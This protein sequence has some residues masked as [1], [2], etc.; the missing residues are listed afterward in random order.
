[1]K[2]Q[3]LLV[4][5]MA[6]AMLTVFNGFSQTFELKPLYQLFTSSTCPGC[7]YGNHVLD[8]VLNNNDGEYS[9]IKYQVNWPGSGDP[10]YTVE[11]GDR[12]NYY[13]VNAV[14]DLFANS[15][16][17]LPWEMTQEVFD[18]HSG[19]MTSMGIQVNTAEVD[20][21]G[22]FSVEVSLTADAAYAAGL[23]L[24]V[25]VVERVTTGNV[26]DNLET[27][28]HNVM[29]KMLPSSSGFPL[30][31]FDADETQTYSFSYDMTE[32][33]MEQA[34]DLRVIVFVQDDN[35]KSIIQSEMTDVS[36][37][38]D[39]Y[40][41]TFNVADCAGNSVVGAVVTLQGV[42]SLTTNFSGQLVYERLMNGT[43][44]YDV[45]AAG[46]F[47]TTGSIEIQ[48]ASVTEEVGMEIP[49][50]LFYEDFTNDIPSDWTLYKEGSDY[51]YVVDGQVIFFQQS[52]G[53]TPLML[54]TPGIDVT[55]AEVL[56]FDLGQQD[57]YT[58]PV[59]GFGYLTD[60]TDPSTYVELA[61]YDVGMDMETIDYDVSGLDGI[62]YFA[63]N[64]NG[65]IMSGSFYR[66]D[67]VILEGDGSPQ[68]PTNLEIEI[69]GFFA[70]NLNWDEYGGCGKSSTG[71]EGFNVWRSIDGSDYEV[72]ASGLTENTYNDGSLENGFYEYYVTVVVDEMESSASNTVSMLITSLDEIA[73]TT[74]IYPNP[75][76]EMINITADENIEE[77]KIFN[78]AGQLVLQ[79][80]KNSNSFTQ[81]IS[82]LNQGIYMIQ[83]K[84]SNT[85][86]TK[87][88]VIE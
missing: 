39:T 38:F 44:A 59:C 42:G 23:T 41:A 85:T 87:R 55:D 54:V 76:S 61:T 31:A 26:G 45:I 40:T 43:Y 53:S 71:F 37:L 19:L 77:V 36:T 4:L 35:D 16:E 50:F 52:D 60:P 33:F 11:A 20:I 21:D 46:L 10:Y 6:L 13:G 7:N 64:H 48:D 24:Q 32:T 78:Q 58:N 51:L 25:V 75:A 69:D 65:G 66:F 49:S 8:S 47:P 28:F 67:N 82:E 17:M 79:A 14:P 68:A 81:N 29:L 62:V 88:I 56:H 70:V 74:E 72:V 83:L 30:E 63:W 22:V 15:T 18:D 73:N 1:M 86:I 80:R 9:L 84:T 3:T 2:K 5:T 34:S 12:V 27:E 57:G